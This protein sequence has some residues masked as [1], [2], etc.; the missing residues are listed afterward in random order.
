MIK[1]DFYV[2]RDLDSRFSEREQFAVK[3]WLDSGYDF[4]FMRGETRWYLWWIFIT[5]FSI[6]SDHPHHGVKILGSG[7]GSKLVREETRMNWQKAWNSGFTDKL[8]WAK[9]NDYGPDQTFLKRYL[10]FLLFLICMYIFF[11]IFFKNLRYVWN[12]AK[13]SSISH[14]SYTC[15]N[16]P[17]T[18]GF[19][20]R[21]KKEPNNFV[22]SGNSEHFLLFATDYF[23]ID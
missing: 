23:F 2:S 14:D 21:R 13:E 8:V 5:Y 19:P 9:R 16:Y 1:V 6:L 17:R 3:E 15:K 22:A 10:H 20:T 12:W 4:H 18:K 11:Y 7:W